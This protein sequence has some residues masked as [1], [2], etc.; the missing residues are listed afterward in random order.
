MYVT[1]QLIARD[2]EVCMEI[3]RIR[4]DVL[5]RQYHGLP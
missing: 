4:S 5:K 1:V 3:T 2:L